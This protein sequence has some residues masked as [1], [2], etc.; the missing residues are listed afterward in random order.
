[1]SS[2]SQDTLT[3]IAVLAMVA[4]VVAVA[5]WRTVLRVILIAA[6]A[7]AVYGAITVLYGLA[8]V[9]GSHHG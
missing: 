8:S 2:H 5:Y 6:I 4:A 1:M 7:L 3:A 9:M